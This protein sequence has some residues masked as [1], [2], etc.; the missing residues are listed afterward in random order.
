MN[1]DKR[2]KNI[3]ERIRMLEQNGMDA[4]RLREI[5]TSAVGEKFRQDSNYHIQ[6]N[7]RKVSIR[8][9]LI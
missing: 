3:E 5:L 6:P 4:S 7:R 1:N 2:L 8:G 9:K